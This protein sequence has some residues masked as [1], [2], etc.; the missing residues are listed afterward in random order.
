M[1]KILNCRLA[2]F[3]LVGALGF[4]SCKVYKQSILFSTDQEQ[5]TQQLQQEVK[6]AQRNYTVSPFDYITFSVYTNKGERIIDPDFELSKES[7][8]VLQNQQTP[9]QYIV[10]PDGTLDLP[11][12]G[13]VKAAGLKINQLD[14]ALQVLYNNF[15]SD[16]YVIS[17]ITNKR[18]IV[19]GATGGHLIPFQNENM[20]LIEALAI[21]M[22][23]NQGTTKFNA[24]NIRIIRGDLKNPEVY[25][26]DLSTI[27]G[28]KKSQT[29]L[30]P[31]DII[32]IEPVVR[33]FNESIRDAAPII[34]IVTNLITLLIIIQSTQTN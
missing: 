27:E 33:V 34:G 15:Y 31:D 32:Y 11:M 18:V 16:S 10:R 28:M 3:M 14:S 19:I 26:I 17:R 9:K 30:Q 4:S 5:N 22:P 6:V 8:A 29:Q 21:A 7:S 12:I 24:Q 2:L 20:S 23:A 1:D 13:N 25:I